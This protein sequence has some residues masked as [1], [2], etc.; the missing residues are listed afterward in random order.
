MGQEAS[1]QTYQP[2]S[3]LCPFVRLIWT[4]DDDAPSS[5]VQLIPPDGCPELVFDLASPSE[6]ASLKG[7]YVRQAPVILSGQLTRPMR[8]RATGPLKV[9]AVR[10]EPDGARDFLGRPLSSITDTRLDLTPRLSG[11][12]ADLQAAPAAV[13]V[14]T[15]WLE[16]E[17]R[18]R[19]WRV[20]S[21]LRDRISGLDADRPI[22]PLGAAHRRHL[23]RLYLDRVGVSE[24]SLKSIL[25]FRRVFD[26][27]EA[28][29][30]SWLEAALKAG[31]FDQ[32][33]M[34]RDFQRFLGCSATQ[35]ARDQLELARRLTSQSYKTQA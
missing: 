20:D 30:T 6:E 29:G 16:A 15:R 28:E 9:I 27:A 21:D 5:V 18:A 12:L 10:F 17:C 22:S 8:L 31:Y 4:Y 14:L 33:Q 35:W 26:H 1:Y 25:R 7:D 19:N 23:Q 32:P 2:P 3:A 11:L 24:R 13:P 34:A